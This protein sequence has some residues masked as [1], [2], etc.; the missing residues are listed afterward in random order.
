MSQP[1]FVNAP[2]DMEFDEPKS[3]FE[4]GLV[5]FTTIFLVVAI[6]LVVYECST[7]YNVTF[8]MG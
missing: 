8:G 2:D 5:V 4:T 6:A 3:G 1:E 7:T